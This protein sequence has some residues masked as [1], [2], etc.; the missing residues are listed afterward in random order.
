M[1]MP[2]YGVEKTGAQKL[3][4]STQPRSERKNSRLELPSNILWDQLM[5]TEWLGEATSE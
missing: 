1:V 5:R 4:Y 3:G 2:M